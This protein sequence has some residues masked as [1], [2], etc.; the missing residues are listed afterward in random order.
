MHQYNLA[1]CISD[2]AGRYPFQ[3]AVT[4]DFVYIRLHGSGALYASDYTEEELRGWAQK[5]KTWDR[6]TF[7][8]FD[9]DFNGYAV[10]NA[11]RLKEMLET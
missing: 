2:T 1:F 4:A 10:K 3:E 9:N 7:L 6:E 5:I 11:V 8:Y